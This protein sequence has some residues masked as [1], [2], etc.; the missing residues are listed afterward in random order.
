MA[1]ELTMRYAAWDAQPGFEFGDEI[2]PAKIRWHGS[3]VEVKARLVPRYG[4]TTASIDVFLGGRCILRT[5]GQM[6]VTGSSWA[7]FDHEGSRQFAEL[8]WG[9]ARGHEFPYVLRINDAKVALS[10]VP[11]E[12]PGLSVIPALFVVLLVLIGVFAC[13]L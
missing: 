10:E 3:E 7:E 5:G 9:K 6:K 2:P 4:W 11:V 13:T 8:S 1:S 12:N